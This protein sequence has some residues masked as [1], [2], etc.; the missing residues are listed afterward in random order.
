MATG[1]S[2][3]FK[4][5]TGLVA[6]LCWCISTCL[7]L[8]LVTEGFTCINCTK[9]KISLKL[10]GISK[11][12]F[13][14]HIFILYLKVSSPFIFLLFVI[15]A[16]EKWIMFLTF[17]VC[18]VNY[19]SMIFTRAGTALLSPI[20]LKDDANLI[21]QQLLDDFWW[22][23]ISGAAWWNCNFHVVSALLIGNP[24]IWYVFVSPPLNFCWYIF[25]SNLVYAYW[26]FLWTTHDQDQTIFLIVLIVLGC[27]I[28]QHF[29]FLFI[30]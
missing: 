3:Y 17:S 6:L 1:G 13:L 11:A 21:K 8:R 19:S 4:T 16:L 28:F 22:Y 7:R 12:P 9:V 18:S 30:L 27:Y 24:N 2:Y 23:F 29:L 25:N 10:F 20:Q 14:L 26:N 15:I 5:T